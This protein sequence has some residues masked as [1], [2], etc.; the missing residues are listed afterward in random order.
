MVYV[1]HD[2][3]LDLKGIVTHPKLVKHCVQREFARYIGMTVAK[4]GSGEHAAATLESIRRGGCDDLHHCLLKFS[5]VM[6]CSTSDLFIV[7]TITA[8]EGHIYMS[9]PTHN[10]LFMVP[11]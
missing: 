5:R 10:L 7:S 8:H 6:H 3:T 9:T 4:I 1:C 11:L 2:A